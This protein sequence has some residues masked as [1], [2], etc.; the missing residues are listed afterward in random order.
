MF[1]IKNKLT[2]LGFFLMASCASGITKKNKNNVS[3]NTKQ[4]EVKEMKDR[5]QWIKDALELQRLGI[6]KLG[7]EGIKK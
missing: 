3:V 2:L 5:K 7:I 1:N 4:K 6:G